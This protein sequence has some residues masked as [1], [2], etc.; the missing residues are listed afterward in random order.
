MNTKMIKFTKYLVGITA[1]IIGFSVVTADSAHAQYNV[2]FFGS[3][4]LNQAPVHQPAPVYYYAQ[5]QPVYYSPVQVSC[6]A[7]QQSIVAGNVATWT[8]YVSGGNGSYNFSWS[9]NDNL[10]GNGQSVSKYYYNVGPK[11]ASVTVRSA[12]QSITRAC[13]NTVMVSQPYVVYQVPVQVPVYSYP[14]VYSNSSNYDLDIGCFADPMN[15]KTNQPVSWVSEVSGG[16]GPYRYTWTGSDGLT[17][18]QSSIIKYYATAG[19]KSAILSVT[20]AD[21][22]SAT[23]VCSNELTVKAPAPA[24]KAP[25]KPVV[26]APVVTPA[27]T[28]TPDVEKTVTMSDPFSLAYVPWG[29]VAILVILVL[30]ATVMYLLFNREKI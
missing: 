25:V 16:V 23:R 28:P 30:F 1:L 29:W 27:P 11:N 18:S 15:A 20:S 26:K 5:P 12:G 17:G 22:R 3:F 24:Y 13:S 7:S 6:Y 10:S 19:S 9:G 2:P 14:Q 21:G 4:N 8:A